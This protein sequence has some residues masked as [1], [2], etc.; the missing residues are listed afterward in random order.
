MILPPCPQ[1][2][3]YSNAAASVLSQGV[4]PETRLL[5]RQIGY[6]STPN[7]GPTYSISISG[8][9][10]WGL[11]FPYA[12][13]ELHRFM[14]TGG[15]SMSPKGS[16]VDT[17]DTE[18]NGSCR[19]DSVLVASK[20]LRLYRTLLGKWQDSSSLSRKLPHWISGELVQQMNSR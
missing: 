20:Q 14:I 2:L 1:L 7:D 19:T 11:S 10:V 17:G 3:Q 4:T 15:S 18:G 13:R 12:I 8:G 9:I 6:L 16:D 5:H